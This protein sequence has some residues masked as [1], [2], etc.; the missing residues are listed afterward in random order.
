MN[1]YL[2]DPHDKRLYKNGLFN[3]KLDP[4]FTLWIKLKKLLLT[5]KIVLDTIDLHPVESADKLFF[6]DHSSFPLFDNDLSPYLKLCIKKNINKARFNLII[7]ECPIIKPDSW[8]KKNHQHYGKIF[9]WNDKLVDNKKYFHY[10]WLQNIQKI[11]PRS[12]PFEEK[13]LAVLINAHKTNYLPHE[14][15]S[16]RINV[17]RFFEKNYP[18]DFDLYGVGWDKPLNVKFIYSAL[19]YGLSKVLIFMK[20]YSNSLR[21]FPSYKGRIKNKTTVL[22]Q[23][24]FC[25]CFENMNHIEGYIT[26]KIFDCFIAG[27]IPLYY[28]AS[29]I[30][31]YIPSNTFIDFGQ[32]KTLNEMYTFLKNMNEKTHNKYLTN[33][34]KFLSSPQLQKWHYQSFCNDIFINEN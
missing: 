26:E 12:I 3:P 10:H 24:K 25:I 30:A 23:Y 21:G 1:L 13:K 11:E 2:I 19:K 27:C 15:Y 33:I 22:A 6:F 29:N 34:K 5:K 8:N 16:L 14:L 20:D 31:A 18:Q 9:T 32:F 28:G 7:T 17:I 4:N